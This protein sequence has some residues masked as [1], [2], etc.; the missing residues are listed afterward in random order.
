M[1]SD[2]FEVYVNLIN[3]NQPQ[4]VETLAVDRAIIQDRDIRYILDTLPAQA[5][6]RID[7]KSL[8]PYIGVDLFYGKEGSVKGLVFVTHSHALVVRIPDNAAKTSAER[9]EK[10]KLEQLED[11]PKPAPRAK[12]KG[13]KQKQPL[14]EKTA[15]ERLR[16]LLDANLAAFGMAQISLTL[17]DTL[18]ERVDGVNLSTVTSE[19]IPAPARKVPDPNAL[20]SNESDDEAQGKGGK[21]GQSRGRGG[22]GQRGRRSR[23]GRGGGNGQRGRGRGGWGDRGDRGGR[24]GGRGRGRG[25]GRNNQDEAEDRSPTSAQKPNMI[26]VPPLPEDKDD[27]WDRKLLSPGHMV[28]KLY[29]HVSRMDINAVFFGQD[30]E[31]DMFA[32]VAEAISR[33]W[34]AHL[35]ANHE[36]INPLVQEAPMIKPSRLNDEELTFF[37]KSMVAAWRVMGE[38]EAERAIEKEDMKQGRM[39]EIV[40]QSHKKRIRASKHQEIRVKTKDGEEKVYYGKKVFG[41]ARAVKLGENELSSEDEKK[42]EKAGRDEG[43]TPKGRKNGHR[44][45]IFKDMPHGADEFT[46]DAG[47]PVDE[48]EAGPT[49]QPLFDM[50][51]LES[52]VVYGRAEATRSE[53]S[54]D[55]F[56]LR[57]LEGRAALHGLEYEDCEFIRRVWFP[58]PAQTATGKKR[59]AIHAESLGPKKKERY[60]WVEDSWGDDTDEE[61]AARASKNKVPDSELRDDDTEDEE[62]GHD[63]QLNAM[64]SMIPGLKGEINKR[65]LEVI[66]RVTAPNP[67]GRTRAT[68]VHGPPGTGKTSTITAAAI[69]LVKS[70]EYVWIVAQSNA[71]ISNVAKKLLKIKFYDFVLIVA[72]E[73]YSWWEG[74]YADLK[75]YVVRT[76]Q[77]KESKKR[78]LGKK[79]I[80][81]TLA[82]LSNSSVEKHVMF[83]HVPLCNLIIDEASQIDMTSEF[84]HLF[85]RQRYAL[86]NVCWF[87]D[88]MQL[89]PYG[90]SETAKINDI[91]KVEHLQANSKLMNISYRLPIPIADFIGKEVYQGE[92]K[93]HVGHEVKTPTQA[94][95]FVDTLEGEEQK[96]EKG[97]SFMN[98]TEAEV[99]VKIVELYYNKIN[100]KTGKP[101]DFT[102]ITPYEA[103]RKLVQGMLKSRGIEKEEVYNVDSFQGNEADYIITTLTKT[104]FSSF[105]SSINRL[106]VLL[107]RCKKGLVVVSKKEFITRT[108]GLLRGL[109]WAY[110]SHDIWKD[111][112]EVAKGYVD[113]PGS[114][115]PVKRPEEESEEE[116]SESE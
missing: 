23:G 35:V 51:N 11:R 108:G 9:Y 47:K 65:Q 115:A 48:E 94:M 52:V 95:L 82:S 88:P 68:L 72:E 7:Q 2:T 5:E 6:A 81:C 21:G 26:P 80:L 58:T 20:A 103:Q 92:L 53:D 78:F 10:K 77:L 116:G 18:R 99:V 61:E 93:H 56:I 86:K 15:Y 4:L 24:G 59:E 112:D 70:E 38:E 44:R 75:P 67:K 100:K 19:A 33:A 113:L 79:L 31:S 41:N 110:E 66:G 22:N 96:E 85:F 84:M 55:M 109:W 71:G 114:P 73:Y 74:Q 42:P 91:F 87:G 63:L 34:V 60:D 36:E 28:N 98:Q 29:P 101:Y 45:H 32:R 89:P 111:A 3:K 62:L 54:R 27:F 37:S 13:Q 16:Q 76:I 1:A 17:W 104:T 107:T 102:V 105:L 39:N 50:D 46:S 14:P 57:L 12:Y 97:T 90:W 69:R 43:A 83:Q 49:E 40:S 25:R 106:N 30:Q 8:K 64:E